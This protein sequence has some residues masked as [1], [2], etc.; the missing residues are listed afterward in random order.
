MPC[1]AVPAIF[2][3][4]SHRAVT[5]DAALAERL[6][7]LHSHPTWLIERW[8]ARFG[9]AKTVALLEANNRAPEVTGAIQNPAE[10][11]D[12]VRALQRDAVRIETGRWLRDAFRAS[13]GSLSH[14]AA[15]R[16]GRISI[17]DEASQM[18]PL[19]LGVH[20]GDSVLDLC[21]APGGKTAILV[22]AAGPHARVVAA[23][24]HAHRLAAIR[25]NCARLGLSDVAIVELD[26]TQ[27]LPFQR[28][29][30]RI[31]VDA[32]CSGTGTLGRNPE[33]R[34]TLQQKDLSEFH[35]RQVALLRSGLAQLEPGG[36]LVYSTCSL[37]AEEN[38]DVIAAALAD[39]STF[40]RVTLEE[41]LAALEPH[42]RDAAPV[43]QERGKP[44]QQKPAPTMEPP[45]ASFLDQD[46]VFRTF[47]P[48][49]LRGWI[50]CVCYREKPA[51]LISARICASRACTMA[52]RRTK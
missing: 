50:L 32:P 2:A 43:A 14:T 25:A 49:S 21:A 20:S 52:P 16:E 19:L 31:L 12:V 51:P 39:S 41:L 4:R 11:E 8:L 17:Q 34:W 38:E 28:R 37:E 33:I 35:E 40:R 29:F 7:I 45:S 13:G 48:D 26:G 23:D 6:G 36:R 44:A 3:R 30:A 24:R 5:G 9:E 27:S 1:C 22:R 18:V 15:Y 10:R 47:P 42:F 46:G